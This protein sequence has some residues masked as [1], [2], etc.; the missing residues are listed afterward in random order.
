LYQGGTQQGTT[1]STTAIFSGL[2]CNTNYTLALD[3]YDA[4]GNHSTKVTLMV[5]TTSCP[6]TTPPTAPT[7]LTASNVTASSLTLGWSPSSD[8]TGVTGYDVYKGGTV[9]ANVPATSSAQSGLACGTS[10]NFGVVA[11]DAA[12]N[13]SAMA[14][15]SP[16]TASCPAPTWT[17]SIADGAAVLAGTTWTATVAPL[18]DSV[19][20]WDTPSGGASN[21][22][23][24]DTSAPYSVALNLP[25]GTYV[26]GVCAWYGTSRTCFDDRKTMTITSASPSTPSTS[27]YY[28]NLDF[29]QLAEPPWTS[30][31]THAQ[32]GY[33][34]PST[35]VQQSSDGRVALVGAPDGVGKA[36]R[37][38]LD[39]GDTWPLDTSV[40]RSQLAM[41]TQAT[42]NKS[43]LQVG[44][45]RW[46]DYEI[47]MPTAFDFPRTNW[48]T[49]I[50]IHPGGNSWGAC[51]LGFDGVGSNSVWMTWKVAGGSTTGSTANLKY[52]P[53]WQLTNADGSKYSPSYN[54]R[55]HLVVGARFAPDN[56]GWLEIWVDGKNVFPRT[57][58]PT[59]WAGDTS[60][61][62]KIGPYKSESSPFP[63]GKSV[64]Y[65][66]RVAIGTA[67]P[68]TS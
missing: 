2:V 28:Y 10:Y 12:G 64:I 40:D 29:S 63:S 18:P 22:L 61:Y 3:A 32:P 45:V 17:S 60:S 11:R 33:Y 8:N 57:N 58:R 48:F 43:A 67:Q 51:D 52:I 68:S 66:T 6:D 39:N 4:A 37:F 15:L 5:S 16:S 19:E 42:W 14:S 49:L 9:V 31:Q 13:S 46:F 27:S 21:K 35:P 41:S 1:A 7:S 53:L 34:E 25:A 55:I 30:I 54:R 20:F 23:A 56:T 62:L 26:L 36:L 47:Y 50:G 65:F 44:D 24:T 38:E 59:M